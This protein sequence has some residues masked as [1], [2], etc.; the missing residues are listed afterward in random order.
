MDPVLAVFVALAVAVVGAALYA[1]HEKERDRRADLRRVYDEAEVGHTVR[2]WTDWDANPRE[3]TAEV[4]AKT[5]DALVLRDGDVLV[6]RPVD[7][8][9]NVSNLTLR[10][11][12]H[13][14]EQARLRA[15]VAVHSQHPTDE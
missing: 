15:L 9:L 7:R 2:Y 5:G 11:G 3:V 14:A 10:R 12:A 1:E 13:D 4:V 8:L 6:E